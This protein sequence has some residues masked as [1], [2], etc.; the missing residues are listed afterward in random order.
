MQSCGSLEQVPGFS[1]CLRTCS[2]SASGRFG[3][4]EMV[5]RVGALV[6]MHLALQVDPRLRQHG[7]RVL[8]EPRVKVLVEPGT[9]DDLADLLTDVFG[10]STILW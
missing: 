6:H 7:M 5:I 4:H 2:S 9:S 3:M 10:H 8:H 1:F